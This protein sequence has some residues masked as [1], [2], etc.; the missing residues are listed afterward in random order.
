MNAKGKSTLYK[1]ENY[2]K[3]KNYS[4]NTIAVYMHYVG[5]LLRS[6]KKPALHITKSELNNYILD[7]NYTSISKQNQV[8]SSIKLFAKYILNISTDKLIFERPRKEKRLPR[9]LDKDHVV[10]SINNVKNL[11]HKA[12]LM[13]GAS[14]GLR[15]SEVCNLKVSDIDS[16]KMIINIHQSKGRK[17]RIV[18]LS[19]NVLKALRLYYRK[20]KPNYY[21][22]EGVNKK[23][24]T[25][26]CNNIVKRYIGYD[27]HF[28]LLRHLFASNLMEQDVSTRKIQSLLGHSSSKTVDIYT[29]VT[30]SSLKGLPLAI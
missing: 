1:Y 5:E 27:C 3:V 30:I 7:Y 29:H 16:K 4:D 24:S 17:D 18:P 14:A 2:L 10:N 28:H 25:T 21:L 19:K 13:I 22:F 9:I 20:Y 23:Y 6:F 26:S 11:K 15:V 12:I 8:Y